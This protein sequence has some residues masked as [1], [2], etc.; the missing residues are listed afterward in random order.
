MRKPLDFMGCFR[1]PR[2]VVLRLQPGGAARDMPAANK[3]LIVL[4]T[5]P[6]FVL[7]GVLMAGAFLL[8]SAMPAAAQDRIPVPHKQVISANPF[9]LMF[10]WF[11]VDYERKINESNTWGASASM[12]SL[13]DDTDY[14]NT[15]L[16]Y[17]YYPQGAALTGFYLGGR[18][19]MHTVDLA[20]EN[21]RFF[22][23]GFELGYDWLIG[24]KRNVSIGVGAGAT[25][26][27]GGDLNGA[28]MTIPTLRLINVGIAF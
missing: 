21:G 8:A 18:G 12:L 19:G 22:G 25:R 14:V 11:N 3:E 9:G 23:L 15:Q 6:R 17:R 16:A 13:G 10:G 2:E 1:R 27:F 24:S 7:A 4:N 28:T 5:N 26:L 20:G